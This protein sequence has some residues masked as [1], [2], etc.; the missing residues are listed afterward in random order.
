[1]K[2]L[3]R[4]S[5]SWRGDLQLQC[6]IRARQASEARPLSRSR[7]K[8]RAQRGIGFIGPSGSLKT[9]GF[10]RQSASVVAMCGRDYGG[11]SGFLAHANR[12]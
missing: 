5:R 10:L 12:R 4:W 6:G 3:G 1:M 8:H 2:P 11:N 7:A 9:E